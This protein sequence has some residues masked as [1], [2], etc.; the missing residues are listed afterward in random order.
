MPTLL[1]VA[2]ELYGLDPGA[3][4]P[5]RDARVRE[6]RTAGDGELALRVRGLRK[7]STSAWVV[8]LLVRSEPDDVAEV[9]ALGA[10]F[11]EAQAGMD[12]ERLRELTARRRH[13]VAVVT[14][15]A[16]DLAHERGTSVSDAVATQVESCLTAAMIDDD[17]ARAVRSGLLVG[18]IEATGWGPAEVASA[19]AVPD[20]LGLA[21]TQAGHDVS[22][23]SGRHLH[24]VPDAPSS[25]GASP[26][27]ATR[28]GREKE[29]RAAAVEQARA[30]AT[31]AADDV[32]AAEGERDAAQAEVGRIEALAL[33][34]DAE[35]DVARR[36][37]DE[38][39]AEA[40]AVDAELSGAVQSRKRAERTLA[41]AVRRRDEAAARFRDLT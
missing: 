8:N 5:A 26:A 38:L 21:E 32:R 33:R 12:R 16:R 24:A 28:R 13:L 22:P 23:G 18:A 17:A 14:A 2:A 41:D 30:E 34:V 37:L 3:F 6:L 29:D 27:R 1:E 25:G 11:R 9:T 35:R 31:E 7:P 19:V 36:R 39:D 40:G 20:E 10:A 4:V 15:R